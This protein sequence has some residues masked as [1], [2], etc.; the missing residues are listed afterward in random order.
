MKSKLTDK[1]WDIV[2][3]AFLIFGCIIVVAIIPG[4]L[5]FIVGLFS[6]LLNFVD[7]YISQGYKA[8]IGLGSGKWILS[9]ITGICLYLFL[10]IRHRSK[11][12]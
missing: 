8:F 2:S 11:N 9:S 3:E 10:K 1:T 5:W 6:E 12:K 7:K 4:L